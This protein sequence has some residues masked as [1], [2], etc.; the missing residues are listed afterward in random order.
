MPHHCWTSYMRNFPHS[1]LQWYT[2]NYNSLCT[3]R[4]GSNKTV[5]MHSLQRLMY[6]STTTDLGHVT[7]IPL[8]SQGPRCIPFQQGMNDMN[9]FGT[10]WDIGQTSWNQKTLQQ[11]CES[12]YIWPGIFIVAL[13]TQQM[14]NELCQLGKCAINF[15]MPI[16]GY[17]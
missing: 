7:F 2:W 4:I 11:F 9:P 14:C 6:I 8:Q 13:P 3:F 5:A 10:W 12:L 15:L 16:C 1:T 17:S